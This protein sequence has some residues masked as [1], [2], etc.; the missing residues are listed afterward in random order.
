[1]AKNL[2]RGRFIIKILQFSSATVTGKIV[3]FFLQVLYIDQTSRAGNT[4]PFQTR[5]K[6][7]FH[8]HQLLITTHFNSEK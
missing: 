2:H 6:E 5:T 8:V 1:M 3:M 7:L 4:G